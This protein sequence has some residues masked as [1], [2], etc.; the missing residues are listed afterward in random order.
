MMDSKNK[1]GTQ[2]AKL[3]IGNLPKDNVYTVAGKEYSRDEYIKHYMDVMI[4][5]IED[6]GAELR[7][8][9][10]VIRDANGNFVDYY[11][12]IIVKLLS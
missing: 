11:L 10:G 9:I 5:N 1:L 2:I 7:D 6:D 4:Q 3:I 12:K 8:D